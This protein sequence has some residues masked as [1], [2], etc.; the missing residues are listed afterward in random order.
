MKKI[1]DNFC[2]EEQVW[3]NPHR[4]EV[5]FDLQKLAGLIFG[6]HIATGIRKGANYQEIFV[7]NQDGLKCRALG[8]NQRDFKETVMAAWHLRL[9]TLPK[10]FT[11]SMEINVHNLTIETVRFIH[12]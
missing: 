4:R 6:L 7:V 8:V 9:P 3:K 5:D 11:G 12:K 10:P 2:Y 1:K